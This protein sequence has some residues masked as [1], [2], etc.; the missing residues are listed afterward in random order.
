MIGW[1]V[2]GCAAIS[3]LAIA[4]VVWI[5]CRELSSAIKGKSF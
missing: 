5:I 3:V 4:G 1:V 2:A